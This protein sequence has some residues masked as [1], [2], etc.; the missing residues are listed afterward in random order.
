[1]ETTDTAPT[2]DTAAMRALRIND[3]APDF[4]ARTTQ[5]EKR[6]SDYRGRWLV[7]FSHPADFTPVCTSEFVAL[8]RQAD[9]FAAIDCDLMALSVDSLYSHLAWLK[10]IYRRFGVKVPFPIIEDPSMAIGHAFGMVDAGSS[11]SATVPRK[12]RNQIR[13]SAQ[14]RRPYNAIAAPSESSKLDSK[15]RPGALSE[16]SLLYFRTPSVGGG[17]G[18]SIPVSTMRALGSKDQREMLIYFAAVILCVGAILLVYALL[19]SR[20]GLALTAIRD[21]EVS[22]AAMGKDV[23]KR[24]LQIFIIGSAVVVLLEN[25]LGEIGGFLAS[26]TGVE[27]FNTLGES[28]TMVTGLIFVICVLAFRRGIIGEIANWIKKPL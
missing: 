10:D 22:A 17:S 13:Y 27:W 16:S 21:N 7:L 15:P 6:L 2:V 4:T 25:K 11:D 9:A 26:V 19:R 24:H 12:T 5:G 8:A 20:I 28:V 18:L 14:Y 1:M 3:T 23:T